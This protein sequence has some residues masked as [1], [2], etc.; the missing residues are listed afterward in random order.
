MARRAFLIGHNGPSDVHLDNLQFVQNDVT[1][2]GAVLNQSPASFD[3]VQIAQPGL[4]PAETLH[5]FE[6][7]ATGCTHQDSLLLYFSGH[8]HYHRG[9]LY[10]IWEDT[11]FA[12]LVST[13][14][15]ISMIK[16]VFANSKARVRLL[17]LDCCHSGA[18]GEAQ[19]TKGSHTPYLGVIYEAARDSASLILTACGRSATT[20]EIPDLKSGYLTHLLVEALST[21]FAE[22][23]IDDDGLLSI[24]DFMEWCSQQT[25]VF[26]QYRPKSEVIASPELYGD[27]RSAVYLTSQRVFFNDAFND[28]LNREVRQAVTALRK[29]YAENK[30]LEY[31]QLENL[32]RP[33]RRVAPTFTDLS[34]LDELFDTGDDAAIF[35]AAVILH[36]RRDRNYME[37]LITWIDDG[38]LRGSAN[39]RVLR[40]VRD[41]IPSYQLSEVG[42]ADLIERL[43]RAALRRETK[44]GPMFARGTTMDMI[45]QV[46]AKLRIPVDQ[47]FTENQ[48]AHFPKKKN[49]A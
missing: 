39:W 15:P 34:I 49:A 1:N 3:Q 40:A 20:R 6:I 44:R 4:S 2:L 21:Q 11:D 26:N 36:I 33:L 9:Q 38:S 13:S 30:W 16:S 46:C 24:T 48:L 5:Q 23:D 42:R 10:L 22:A 25:V 8:G 41:T 37:K 29:A 14:L 17:I 32:A 45:R 12:R 7:L 31:Q 19:F 18:A 28:G 35:A 27:F 43:R 47:V